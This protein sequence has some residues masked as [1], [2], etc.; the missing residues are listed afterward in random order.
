M[1]SDGTGQ[2]KLTSPA[3]T[4]YVVYALDNPGKNKAGF[5]ILHFE[6]ID[7]TTT[8]PTIIFAER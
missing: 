6:M 5:L 2:I 4:T 8:D 1:M 7:T 3:A